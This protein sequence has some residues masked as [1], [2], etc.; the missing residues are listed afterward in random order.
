MRKVEVR[1]GVLCLDPE[2]T[3]Y[4]GGSSPKQH[5]DFKTRLTA[6]I[7]AE[8]AKMKESGTLVRPK[9]SIRNV[10]GRPSTYQPGN[11]LQQPHQ[12]RNVF[13][14]GGPPARG[15]GGTATATKTKASTQRTP[16]AKQPADPTAPP[17][18]P[19]ARKPKESEG[20]NPKAHM[21]KKSLNQ[22]TQSFLFRNTG[23]AGQ[24]QP[25]HPA[26]FN[27]SD[28][29]DLDMDAD[30]DPDLDMA[31]DNPPCDEDLEND[32]HLQDDLN[33]NSD[34]YIEEGDFE[35]EEGDFEW[36]EGA[37]EEQQA[38]EDAEDYP[39][40]FHEVQGGSLHHDPDANEPEDEE[41]PL[42]LNRRAAPAPAPAAP[43]QP[44]R[45]KFDVDD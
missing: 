17:K 4:L 36:N 19:R 29:D 33:G 21:N 25:S 24:Q 45:R 2:N 6:D 14:E 39:S 37:A 15:A 7:E 41:E 1:L 10:T 44:K 43:Q 8:R 5:L 30:V 18:A 3:Q 9:L 31:Q 22:A 27:D 34:E 26:G 40:D 42:Q 16:R 23:P 35:L 28:F 12:Q 13:Q 20:G 11:Q 32:D 38:W